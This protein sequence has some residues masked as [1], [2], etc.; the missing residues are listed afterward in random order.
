MRDGDGLPANA[1]MLYGLQDAA[2]QRNFIEESGAPETQKRIEHLKLNALLGFVRGRPRAAAGSSS[3]TS[4]T[5]RSRAVICDTCLSPPITFDGT[6]AA[7][8][9]AFVFLS[10][11]SAVR[12]GYLVDVLLG[13]SDERI[14]PLRPRQDQ[15]LWNWRRSWA[16][17]NGRAF[18]ASSS[19]CICSPPTAANMGGLKITEKGHAF[20]KNKETLHLRKFIG[21]PQGLRLPSGQN[22]ASARRARRTSGSSPR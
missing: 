6:T 14:V 22:A 20:L 10:Y 16:G 3:T 7:Q 2:L 4:A 12:V 1:L 8:E 11:R 5:A 18:T 13:K 19:R 15:H 17:A 21:R 9:S